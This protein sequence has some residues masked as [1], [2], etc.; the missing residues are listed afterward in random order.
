[1]PEYRLDELSAHSG[2]TVRN[3][4]A[5]R[6]RGLLDP[7]RRQGRSAYYDERHLAQLATINELLRKGF[8]SAHIAEFL[9]S[10]RQG[11]DLADVLGLQQAIFG[12][13]RDAVAAVDIDPDGAEARRLLE[14]GL[15]N[16][17]D[18]RVRLINPTVAEIVGRATD[19]LPYVQAILGV[20]DRITRQLDELA[21]AVVEAL[22][23]SAFGGFGRDDEP[24]AGDAVEL[25]RFLDDYGNVG[26]GIVA[27]KFGA[28][29][30]HRL[31]AAV[32][33]RASDVAL[34][35]CRSGST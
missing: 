14:H 3:I 24:G 33:D 1:L 29:L 30:Q 9:D 32:S 28:A 35:G 17:V 23:E 12:E 16:V 15:A 26:R 4:R 18:G 6:E 31:V 19:Q 34:D 13:P 11:H 5:Y 27:D 10:T 8:T 21:T 7:P 20:A 22:E 2:V 25:G